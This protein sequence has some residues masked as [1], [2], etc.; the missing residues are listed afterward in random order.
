MTQSE[1]L[2]WLI[3]RQLEGFHVP[4][5][6]VKLNLT[7][8]ECV[9]EEMEF[10]ARTNSLASPAEAFVAAAMEGLSVLL[11]KAEE[12]ADRRD[13]LE[14]KQT[15]RSKEQAVKQRYVNP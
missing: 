10:L 14:Q 11:Q 13:R 12:R 3:E 8:R 5:G 15:T 4:P 7:L 6:F 9:M 1:Y 2:R